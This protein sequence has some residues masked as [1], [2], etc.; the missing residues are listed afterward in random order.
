LNKE[1]WLVDAFTQLPFTGNPAGVVP[2]AAGLTDAQMQSIAR[3]INA[4]ETAFVTAA[5]DPN[6]ADLR[7][8]Y[9]TPTR[10]VDLC[11]HATIGTAAS[12]ALRQPHI[13]GESGILHVETNV[14]ILPVTYGQQEGRAWAEMRQ[15]RPRFQAVD[16]DPRFISQLL[17]ILPEDMA[18]EL[19]IGMSY[20]GLWDLFVPLQGLEAMR[21][22]QPKFEELARWNQELGVASTHVYSLETEEH[23]HDYHA[24]DF[25]PAVGILEDPV[26][27]TAT[28][29]LLALLHNHG[30]VERHRTYHFEQGYE[31]M[32]PGVIDAR[33]SE[34]EDGVAVF[35]KGHAV[36]SMHGYLNL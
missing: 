9:F 21:K 7:I 34:T 19:P 33:I 28:G 36:I 27:G 22:L 8:R 5:S 1:V 13:Y 17:G 29:A 12:L 35:V 3:E 2:E 6:R 30:L 26:T 20:T 14:G 15:A 31:M 18:M 11:G 23:Q 24:R 10:E 4:S 25:S 32:R 16:I